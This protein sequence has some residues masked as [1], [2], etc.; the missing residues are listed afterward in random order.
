MV[1][2]IAVVILDVGKR[3]FLEIRS[4]AP[5]ELADEVLL[6]AGTTVKTLVATD[7]TSIC[8]PVVSFWRMSP[9]SHWVPSE[10]VTEVA[11][12]VYEAPRML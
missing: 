3:G 6:N 5:V 10:T 7:K 8:S 9:L 4:S 2:S 1:V 11:P 12:E